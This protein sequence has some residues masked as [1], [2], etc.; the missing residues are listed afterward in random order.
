MRLV[1][2]ALSLAALT[3]CATVANY[4]AECERSNPAFGGT[5]ACL[6]RTFAENPRL[7]NNPRGK[8]YILKAKQLSQQVDAGQKSE[9][10]AR[11][12]LQ[13]LYVELRNQELNEMDDPIIIQ[14]AAQPVLRTTCSTIGGVTSCT[15]R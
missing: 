5:V 1:V 7:G 13:Q 9:L 3:G 12:E 4:Q 14:P 8:L 10:D 11:V 6:E 15:T 2:L